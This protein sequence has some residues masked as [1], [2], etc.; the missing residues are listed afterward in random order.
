VEKREEKLEIYPP[1][2]GSKLETNFE[3]LNVS[4]TETAVLRSPCK[5]ARRLLRLPQIRNE[6]FEALYI[7]APMGTSAATTSR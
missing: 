2:A 7:Y 3:L 5:V 6:R 4:M 1:P